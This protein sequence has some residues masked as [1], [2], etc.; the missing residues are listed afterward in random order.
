MSDR[1][2]NKRRTIL[3]FLVNNPI[4]TVFFKSID[5]SYIS[6]TTEKIFE[7]INISGEEVGEENVVQND[8]RFATSYLTLVCLMD[9]KGI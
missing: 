4:G 7:M 8:N 9:H 3:N 6:K 5:A 1:Q 2:I